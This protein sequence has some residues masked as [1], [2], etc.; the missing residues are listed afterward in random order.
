MGINNEEEFATQPTEVKPASE[1]EFRAWE[2]GLMRGMGV[3]RTG[4]VE[5]RRGNNNAWENVYE[6]VDKEFATPVPTTN[7]PH[8]AGCNC[9]ACET[10]AYHYMTWHKTHRSV[11][12]P[13][14]KICQA[15]V[16]FRK[17]HPELIGKRVG[18]DG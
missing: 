17:Q 7:V 4:A 10:T 15:E 5:T 9:L 2:A 8:A 18:V 14:C 3:A 12:N 16:E 11:P 6:V 13:R 1:E